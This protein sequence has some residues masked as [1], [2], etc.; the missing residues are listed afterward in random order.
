MVFI[1][2]RE[3]PNP[4]K[5]QSSKKD[6]ED[7][8]EEFESAEDDEEEEE[9]EVKPVETAKAPE[10]IKTAPTNLALKKKYIVVKELP[11]REW[12]GELVTPDRRML[13]EKV[14]GLMRTE[15]LE[16][17]MIIQYETIEEYLTRQLQAMKDEQRAKLINAQNQTP[18]K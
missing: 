17:G 13:F 6:F 8:I 11:V 18:T 12:V 10:P 4:N 15:V 16:D 1:E 14:Q 2:K 5:D 9:E 3:D 7:E